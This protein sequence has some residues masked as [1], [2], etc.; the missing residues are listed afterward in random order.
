MEL[1]FLFYSLQFVKTGLEGDRIISYVNL[2]KCY[3]PKG[4]V[5]MRGWLTGGNSHNLL[6][7]LLAIAGEAELQECPESDGSDRKPL[8]PSGSLD[9]VASNKTEKPESMYIYECL[10]CITIFLQFD[11]KVTNINSKSPCN[12]RQFW[13]TTYCIWTYDMSLYSSSYA[14]TIFNYIILR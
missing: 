13:R 10:V 9:P 1:Y 8:G 11:I 14:K 7:S 12:Q 3:N 2:I 5:R 6:R 4:P